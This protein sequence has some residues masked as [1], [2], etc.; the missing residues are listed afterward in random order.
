MKISYKLCDRMNG[1]QFWCFSWF[2]ENSLLYV[3]LLYTVQ[4]SYNLSRDNSIQ[5]SEPALQKSWKSPSKMSKKV[6]ITMKKIETWNILMAR[7][8]VWLCLQFSVSWDSSIE[9]SFSVSVFSKEISSDTSPSSWIDW[10]EL[11]SWKDKQLYYKRIFGSLDQN[12]NF[13]LSWAYL[14]LAPIP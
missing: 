9:S 14:G 7:M 1:S 6:W 4:C 10:Y 2:P 8:R 3:I 5:I 11:F 13:Q 12:G